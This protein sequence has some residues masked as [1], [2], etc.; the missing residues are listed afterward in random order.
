MS[1]NATLGFRAHSG[2]AAVVAVAGSL[3]RPSVLHRLRIETSD[4]T[5]RGSEQPYHAA[6]GL[7]QELAEDLICKCR[8]SS[9]RLAV[10]AVTDIVHQLRKKGYSPIGAGVLFASGRPLPSLTLTLQ[11]HALIHTAEGEFFREVLIRASE[12][13]SLH[14]TKVKEREIWGRGQTIFRLPA[15]KLQRMIAELRTTVGAPWGQD[16]KLACMAAWIA[17]A[18]ASSGSN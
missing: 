9:V 10:D 18:D 14:V 3:R 12:H 4:A 5:I 13:C 17:L 8:D 7:S 15:E 16:E 6:E 11:S 1:E 2:W